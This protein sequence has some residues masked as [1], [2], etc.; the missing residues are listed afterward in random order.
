MLKKVEN[1]SE[2]KA[3]KKFEEASDAEKRV[4]WNTAILFNIDCFKNGLPK[5]DFLKQNIED[6]KKISGLS[7]KE[8]QEVFNSGFSV[9]MSLA[10]EN[11]RS[12]VGFHTHK[13]ND[14]P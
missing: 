13:K 5:A 14:A 1:K 7:S 6:I 11:E 9:S 12:E 8:I 10:F 3:F 2:S 4:A